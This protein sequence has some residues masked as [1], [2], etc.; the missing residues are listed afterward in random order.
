MTRT[1]SASV[2]AFG[3]AGL[4]F[5][6]LGYIPLAII[7]WVVAVAIFATAARIWRR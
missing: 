6:L 3:L 2:I 7:C 4:T 1:T 5:A